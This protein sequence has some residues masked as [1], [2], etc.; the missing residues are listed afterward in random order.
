[1]RRAWALVCLIAW[2]AR[3]MLVSTG[4]M[5]MAAVTP[6]DRGHPSVLALPLGCR[7]DLEITAM[8]TAVTVTP[9]S[10]VLGVAAADGDGVPVMFVHLARGNDRD[11]DLD[12]LRA[13]ER[14]VLAVLGSRRGGHA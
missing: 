7:T 3:E 2:L 13:L 11:A 6:L 12:H 5:L 9:G 10:L 4:R 1:M 8:A 14:R